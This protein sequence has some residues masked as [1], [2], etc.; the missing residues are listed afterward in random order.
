MIETNLYKKFKN[1]KEKDDQIFFMY[2]N[3]FRILGIAD[4]VSNCSK[5]RVASATL[6]FALCK[7][8]K[9]HPITGILHEYVNKAIDD[10]IEELQEVKAL[11]DE[12]FNNL[13]EPTPQIESISTKFDIINESVNT[14]QEE[15]EIPKEIIETTETLTSTSIKSEQIEETEKAESIDKGEIVESNPNTDINEIEVNSEAKIVEEII[16]PVTNELETKLQEIFSYLKIFN[17]ME[18]EDVNDF[19]DSLIDS[20][21]DTDFTSFNFQTTL[22]LN[23]LKSESEFVELNSFNY[24]DSEL[25]IISVNPSTSLIDSQ[26][27]HYKIPQGDL[28][29]Y[30]SSSK[31]RNGRLDISTRKLYENDLLLIGSDGTYFSKTAKESGN[32]FAPLHNLIIKCLKERNLY[33][34]PHLWFEKLEKMNAL[35]DDFSMFLISCKKNIEGVE[36]SE[37]TNLYET[38]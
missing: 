18:Y 29:S 11:F 5:G 6:C 2:I 25:L 38:L 14:T 23:I 16:F 35:D 22:S 28:K 34:L 31:G 19:V 17:E 27:S 20:V 12:H 1:I 7:Y 10:A 9:E 32:P 33:E 3:G 4:G 30:I 8:F 37:D 26:I 15:V 21:A 13:F 24:G 36:E